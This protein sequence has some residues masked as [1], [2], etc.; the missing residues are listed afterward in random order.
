MSSEP[1]PDAF[2]NA[3]LYDCCD[4]EALTHT[5]PEEAV[6]A[7]LDGWMEPGCD[8]LAVIRERGECEITAYRHETVDAQ[9]IDSIANGLLDDLSDWFS[10]TLGNPNGSD[11]DDEARKGSLPFMRQAVQEFVAASRVWRCERV[12]TRTLEADEIE[13]M[14]REYNPSWFESTPT[15]SD[16]ETPQ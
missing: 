4:S 6:E 16:S 12:A 13:A 7:W 10:R 1:S 5:T 3:E 11:S 8:V 15:P 14:M 9:D 2:D